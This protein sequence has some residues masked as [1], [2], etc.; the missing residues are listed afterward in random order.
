MNK[1]LRA[2]G[3]AAIALLAIALIPVIIFMVAGM[4][5]YLGMSIT[6]ALLIGAVVVLF[7]L[8]TIDVFHLQDN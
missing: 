1:L 2:M 3:I 7:I 6:P 5:M 4:L 8:I